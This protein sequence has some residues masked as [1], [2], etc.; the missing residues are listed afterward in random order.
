MASK[1]EK[2]KKAP[3]KKAAAPKKAAAKKSASKTEK[4]ATDE[5]DE[6]DM[7]VS[8]AGKGTSVKGSSKKQASNEDDDDDEVAD[9]EDDWEKPEEE[10]HWDPDFD[11]FD[12]PKSKTK[13][14]SS[15]TAKSGKSTDEFGVDDDFKDMG[16]FDDLGNDFDDDDY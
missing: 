4:K 16:L 2:E 13:K 7:L 11:E 3:L 5:L 12:L 15:G 14:S 9:V 1:S 6:E 10:D 8:P